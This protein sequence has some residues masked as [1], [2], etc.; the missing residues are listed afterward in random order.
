MAL[1]PYEPMPMRIARAAVE[2]S[3]ESLKTFDLAFERGEDRERFFASYHPGQFCQLSIF[4]K[5]E[6]PFGV[7]SATWEDQFVRFTVNKVGLFTR[8]IHGLGTGD[9]LG[10]RGPLGNWFPIEEWKGKSIVVVGGGCA[11]TTLFALAKEVLHPTKRADYEDLTVIYGARTAGLFLYAS[12]IEAWYER[13][14]VKLYQ[15]IDCPEDGWCHLTGYVPTVT[16]EVAP[17]SENAVAV[18]CGPPVMNKFT[19][20]VLFD[21]G[22][23]PD[24]VYTSLEKRMKCGIGKC[25]R[26]NIGHKYVCKDGPIFTMAELQELPADL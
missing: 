19:L 22:F 23:P 10:M 20:P 6:A 2:T 12:E 21:L 7:A 1:N 26:C 13:D 24:R 18:V 5:G 3:D 14:D 8:A 4:G 17:A 15:A 11:F 25:G 16:K 9:A